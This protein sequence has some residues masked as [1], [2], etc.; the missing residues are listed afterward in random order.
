MKKL[1][2]C[3]LVVLSL[4]IFVSCSFGDNYEE[5]IYEV[6]EYF[7][8]TTIG[9]DVENITFVP[10]TDGK[11]KVVCYSE[12]K[13]EHSVE[14]YDGKLKIE[15]DD[16]RSWV[17]K[18]F[19]F[20]KDEN[21]ITVY[22]PT[23]IDTSLVV[24]GDTGDIEIPAGFTFDHINIIIDTGNVVC[25]ASTRHQIVIK[26]DTGDIQI[27]DFTA[28]DIKLETS[29]GNISI[30]NSECESLS[31]ITDTG[32]ITASNINCEN[33]FKAVVDTGNLD[34]SDVTCKLFASNGDSGAVKLES[35]IV[36]ETLIIERS[37]GDIC[38]E[39]CDADEVM[40]TTD[41]GDVK[42]SFLTEKI[43]FATTDTGEVDIPKLTT[44]GRCEI[45]TDTGDIKITINK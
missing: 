6:S 22:L 7:C 39:K 26:S 14:V 35:V 36:E 19:S 5:K 43:V 30:C 2:F 10:S 20:G 38:F 25:N 31:A 16:K 42:G 4:M 9:V 27:N 24:T 45:T 18:V 34:L 17:D 33:D 44:G 8:I 41:T 23:D 13:L 11:C 21:S 29:T 37:T 3:V 1:V 32:D 28:E 12:C 15:S 40:I